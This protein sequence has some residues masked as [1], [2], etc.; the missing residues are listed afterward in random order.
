MTNSTSPTHDD[1]RDARLALGDYDG[2][3]EL[4]PMLRRCREREIGG[5]VRF[6]T[7]GFHA[8]L[9][10]SVFAIQQDDPTTALILALA[11]MGRA[12]KNGEK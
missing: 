10:G 8:D 3:M 7:D 2:P 6:G 5:S 11:A 12:Q 9:Y 1:I 4:D